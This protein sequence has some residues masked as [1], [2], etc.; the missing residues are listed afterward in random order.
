MLLE[1]G[2][3]L[4]GAFNPDIFGEPEYRE[5]SVRLRDGDVLFL[6]TDGLVEVEDSA[7]NALGTDVLMRWIEEEL[8]GAC[9][10]SDPQRLVEIMRDRVYA[11]AGTEVLRDDLSAMAVCV[12]CGA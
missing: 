10:R 8:Q 9:G 11:F 1:K 5:V 3:V 2:D 4:L 12:A 6:Y 7:G